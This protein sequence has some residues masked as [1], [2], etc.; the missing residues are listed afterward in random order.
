MSEK[1]GNGNIEW[2]PRHEVTSR[3]VERAIRFIEHNKTTGKPFYMNLW[4][5]DPHAPNEP[6]P[7]RRGDH[8]RRAL[9]QG[10]VHE[11]DRALGRLLDHIR[12]DPALRDNT[13]IIFTSDNG[14]D[15]GHGSNGNLRGHKTE[16]YEGGV[17]EP[18]IVWAPKLLAPACIGKVNTTTVLAAID[19]APTLLAL[20]GVPIPA[21]AT[22]DGYD[23]TPAL[24]GRAAAPHR[25][26]PLFWSRPPDRPGA[27]NELPDYAVRDAQWKLYLHADGRTELYDLV[28]D[29]GEILEKSADHPQV[30][31]DL[32][33]K[34]A[35]WQKDVGQE[36]I[37]KDP[38]APAPAPAKTGKQRRK[39]N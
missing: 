29:P 27:K 11:L 14:P 33:A 8:S 9:Y 15:R 34:L 7:A 1:L 10:V 36:K 13:I 4:P 22:F 6:S 5:E 25:P 2:A 39:K 32:L 16:L 3:H 18:F 24:L 35:A 38:A 26:A 28:D 37:H 19:L 12:D 23:M 31:K 21:G 20:A 17:R 30:V